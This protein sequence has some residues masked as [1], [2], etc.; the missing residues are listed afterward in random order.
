MKFRNKPLY[1]GEYFLALTIPATEERDVIPCEA[2]VNPN[3]SYRFVFNTL[4]A[5]GDLC[6]AVEHGK[7]I[8]GEHPTWTAAIYRAPFHGEGGSILM[9]EVAA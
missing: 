1:K 2:K 3:G 8:L 6:F 5:H 9:A 7:R 4:Y